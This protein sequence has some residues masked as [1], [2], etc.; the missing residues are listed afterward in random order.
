MSNENT[1]AYDFPRRTGKGPTPKA[2]PT[3]PAFRRRQADRHS[4]DGPHPAYTVIGLAIIAPKN[5]SPD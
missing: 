1:K 2:L 3:D 5:N 4:E